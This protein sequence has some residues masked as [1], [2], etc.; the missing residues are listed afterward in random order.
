MRKLI[1]FSDIH[2]PAHDQGAFELLK[3]VLVDEKPDI[4]IANGD[5]FDLD[6][7]SPYEFDPHKDN[8]F[9]L[10]RALRLWDELKEACGDAQKHFLEGNHEDRLRRWIAKHAPQL[11]GTHQWFSEQLGVFRGWNYHPYGEVVQ[12]GKLRIVHDAGCTG[13][14]QAHRTYQAIPRNVITGHGHRM[15]LTVLGNIEGERHCSMTCGW[16]GDADQALYA[17]QVGKQHWQLGFGAVTIDDNDNCFMQPIP[18]VK[19]GLV[20]SCLVNGHLYTN[21]EGGRIQAVWEN[22]LSTVAEEP[23]C[24]K[25]SK[26]S[27][28]CL[29]KSRKTPT[30]GKGSKN[31]QKK[32]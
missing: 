31:K 12:I 24:K 32:R 20:Y 25:K 28:K 4:V 14:Y 1:V 22:V 3:L 13:P 21:D 27:K 6:A 19:E 16:L 9:E 8:H 5:I 7:F 10:P 23:T 11:H 17:T 26:S 2:F 18:I 29:Q 15:Q 30:S